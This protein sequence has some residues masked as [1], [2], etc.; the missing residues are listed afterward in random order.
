MRLNVFVE[1]E[2]YVLEVPATLLDGAADAL[3]KM[4]HDMNRGWQMSREYVEHPDAMQRCQIVA[5]RLLTSMMNGKKNTALLMAAYILS[6][7]PGVTGVDV[8]TSGEIQNTVMR[9][10][11]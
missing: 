5:D 4:D 9:F 2:T 1:E 7:F 11:T 8:D 6:R 3:A 10:E